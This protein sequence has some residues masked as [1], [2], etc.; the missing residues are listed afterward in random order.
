MVL[1]PR[2]TILSVQVSISMYISLKTGWWNRCITITEDPITLMFPQFPWGHANNCGWSSLCWLLYLQ[3]IADFHKP[4][5]R[6][7]G[8]MVGLQQCLPPCRSSMHVCLLS[9]NGLG[10]ARGHWQGVP[11]M[12]LGASIMAMAAMGVSWDKFCQPWWADLYPT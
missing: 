9:S 4:R 6:T 7:W 8:L 1:N 3:G 2:S 5:R 11:G 10:Y 12:G